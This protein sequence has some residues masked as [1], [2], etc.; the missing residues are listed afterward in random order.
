MNYREH[1]L[2]SKGSFY[3][4]FILIFSLN[5]ISSPSLFLSRPSPLFSL[6]IYSISA[7]QLETFKQRL[8]ILQEVTREYKRQQK[9]EEKGNIISN[10]NSYEKEI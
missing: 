1:T 10:K 3:L 6:S 5:I 7:D 9:T 4:S 8:V 2:T